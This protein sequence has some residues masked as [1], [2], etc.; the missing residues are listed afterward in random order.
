MSY[1][2]VTLHRAEKVGRHPQS[3]VLWVGGGGGPCDGWPIHAGRSLYAEEYQGEDIPDGWQDQHPES[4]ERC[5]AAFDERDD[6]KHSGSLQIEWNTPSG[7]L[8]PG[9]AWASEPAAEHGDDGVCY[10]G[11]SNCDGRHHHVILPNGHEWTIDMR[12][13]N[14]GLDD[15][16][17]RCWVF[18][19]DHDDPTTWHVSKDGNTCDVGE[20]SIRSGDYHGF[21]QH[22]TLTVD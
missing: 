6:H 17:H 3:T 8:E 20:G 10:L 21:L 18:A 4:C 5:G 22:G 19:G 2:A 9:C 15:D 1:E 16:T 7:K 13:S 12:A 14:C 11:W